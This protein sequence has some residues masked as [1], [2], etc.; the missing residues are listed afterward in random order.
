VVSYGTSSPPTDADGL[1]ETFLAAHP[2]LR[3]KRVI[4]YLSRIHEK[5]G[6]DLLLRSFAA[7]AAADAAWH[8][9]MAGPDET[10]VSV[11]LKSLAAE[12]GIADRVSWP[13]MLRGDLKWGAFYCAEAFVLPSHQENFGIAVAEALSCSLPVLIS[14]K[15]NIW[16]EI[17]SDESGLVEADTQAGTDN[18]LRRWLAMTPASRLR[19]RGNARRSFEER[20]TVDSM[21]TS[22]LDVVAGAAS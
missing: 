6:C 12:L 2:D 7:T 1:R 4:L 22:L 3:F 13:G 9:V 20:F 21:A 5:K 16:R 8:L 10:G 11:G 19:M 14:D 15:V 18:L 17:Q